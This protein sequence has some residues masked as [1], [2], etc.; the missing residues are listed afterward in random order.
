M[1]RLHALKLCDH[2]C[3]TLTRPRKIATPIL[4]LYKEKIGGSN[5][6]LGIFGR[7]RVSSAC[8]SSAQ[9]ATVL[10]GQRSD[11][12]G[13]RRKK[14]KFCYGIETFRISKCLMGANPARIFG[15]AT[16]ARK[17]SSSR[18]LWQAPFRLSKHGK[19]FSNRVVGAWN[20]L[21]HTVSAGGGKAFKTRQP[22]CV[23]L[24]I[25]L[26]DEST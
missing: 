5:R 6:R 10:G 21:R 8:V 18:N 19:R 9:M 17:R 1:L 20:K 14:S 2:S 11:K 15:Y 12:Q 16:G 22:E 26:S 24:K 7:E 13:I 23:V 4:E 25:G 3:L